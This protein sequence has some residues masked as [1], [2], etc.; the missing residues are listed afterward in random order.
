LKYLTAFLSKPHIVKNI[1]FGEDKKE[2][3]S[4]DSKKAFM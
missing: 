4:E 2:P 3:W 1:A